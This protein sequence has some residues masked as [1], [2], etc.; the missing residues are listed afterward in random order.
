LSAYYFLLLTIFTAIYRGASEIIRDW[1]QEKE[2]QLETTLSG[3]CG[4]MG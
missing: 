1:V 3:V 4:Q 2:Y